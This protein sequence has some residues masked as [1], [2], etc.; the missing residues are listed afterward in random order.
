MRCLWR[1]MSCARL[2]SND[3]EVLLKDLLVSP[4]YSQRY[5]RALRQ[6][7][8]RQRQPNPLLFTP[9]RSC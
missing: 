5:L 3:L 2:S 8:P 7:I 9:L 4:R 6:T 1:R